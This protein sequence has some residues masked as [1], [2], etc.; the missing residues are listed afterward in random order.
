MDHLFLDDRFR[1]KRPFTAKP[2]GF[3]GSIP[4]S[5]TRS[6][7]AARLMREL[8]QAWLQSA[9]STPVA[10]IATAGRTHGVYLSFAIR[11]GYESCIDGLVSERSGIRVRTISRGTGDLA[12]VTIVTVW[13]PNDQHKFFAD[14]I[15]AFEGIDNLTV[16]INPDNTDALKAIARQDPDFKKPSSRRLSS[17][18]TKFYVS[19]PTSKVPDFI[20]RAGNLIEAARIEITYGQ[21]ALITSIDTILTALLDHFCP[22]GHIP[23]ESPEWTEVWLA[24]EATIEGTENNTQ[25]SPEEAVE[26]RFRS[27][28]ENR[29]LSIANERLR[30]PE[31]VVLL[32]EINRQQASDILAS[33]DDIA[34]FRPAES[35]SGYLF[36]QSNVE[37]AE[38]VDNLFARIEP[39]TDDAPAVCVVDTGVNRGHPLLES[40][41]NQT[42]CHA[43]E[44]AWGVD[45]H[46]GHGTEMAGLAAYGSLEEAMLSSGPIILRHRLES[47]KLL[48]PT[49]RTEPHLW[50]DFTDQAVARASGAPGAAAT[51]SRCFSLAITS[52]RPEDSSHAGQPTS[53]S[54][55]LDQIAYG[56]RD[57]ERRLFIV[58]AGNT[59]GADYPR[60]N[61]ASSIESPGQAWNAVTVGCSTHFKNFDPDRF[62]THNPLAKEGD[63]S[64]FSTT[65]VEWEN[66]WPN[67]PDVVF[68]GGNLL[69]D[70]SDGTT[71]DPEDLWLLTTAREH[72]R[73]PFSVTN[74]TSAATAQAANFAGQLMATY[75]QAWPETIR[76]LM[77][78]SAQWTDAMRASF[79]NGGGRRDYAK[80]L[81]IVGYGIPDLQRATLCGKNSLTLVA[82]E[83]IRPYKKKDSRGKTN[84]MHL[85]NLPWPKD[86]LLA[87][88]EQPVSMRVTLSY[89]VDPSPEGRAWTQ[90]YR[91]QSHALRFALKKPGQSVP[92]FLQHINREVMV[93]EDGVAAPNL[94][95][96]GIEDRWL[97]GSQARHRGS[98]HSDILPMDR[99][100]AAELADVNVLA[101]YPVVGWFR[102][103]LHARRFD[104]DVRYSL[105]VSIDTQDVTNDIYTPVAAQI[106]IPVTPTVVI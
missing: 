78:H 54:G 68:E 96:Q 29:G 34:E 35:C 17:G 99:L 73:K 63:L 38:M 77:I 11:R 67:K 55:G 2:S 60:R 27:L 40:L 75:P 69:V 104:D 28:A 1:T 23:T 31:R 72:T 59:D 61:L 36:R 82:Q 80:L 70:Q 84:E 50:A 39:P 89:F 76:A 58:S 6:Q 48:P 101:V 22:I 62:P 44:P 20:S 21:S 85:H 86:A 24:V 18:E 53:W 92:D 57:D 4:I 7:H 30:F 13:V 43:V 10:A 87:L 79:L 103:R 97:I 52:D 15:R 51:R 65:A 33:S 106:R 90:R 32:A 66:K 19:I 81:R 56:Y 95:T 3:S 91:Y 83:T 37:Q 93:D 88:G 12:D 64:P 47:V 94:G 74:G 5:R 100:T 25:T 42:D 46:E 102:E 41:L 45:D 98:V 16:P 14:K 9:V 49:G 8:E 105:I 26:T 71:S